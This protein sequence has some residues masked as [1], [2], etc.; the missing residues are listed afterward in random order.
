MNTILR[1]PHQENYLAFYFRHVYKTDEVYGKRHYVH[2]EKKHK[3]K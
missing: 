1:R 3:T 2:T